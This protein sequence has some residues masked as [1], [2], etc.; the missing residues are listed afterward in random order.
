M[1]MLLC[2]IYAK[3]TGFS[4]ANNWNKKKSTAGWIIARINEKKKY[5]SE[6]N[7]YSWIICDFMQNNILSGIICAG[8]VVL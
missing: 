6:N 3:K 1:R 4:N 5:A 7:N 8:W 2:R